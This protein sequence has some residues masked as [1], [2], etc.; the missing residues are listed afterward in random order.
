MNKSS[1]EKKKKTSITF[2]INKMHSEWDSEKSEQKRKI[3]GF[4]V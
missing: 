3:L 2:S 1:A 4:G